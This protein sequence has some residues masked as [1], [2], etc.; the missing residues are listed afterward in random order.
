MI[1]LALIAFLVLISPGSA[2]AQCAWVLWLGTHAARFLGSPPGTP[3]GMEAL[4]REPAQWEVRGAHSTRALCEEQAERLR[5]AVRLHPPRVENGFAVS[6]P[7]CLP[8]TIDPRGPKGKSQA[9]GNWVMWLSYNRNPTPVERFATREACD[10][11]RY[12]LVGS[13]AKERDELTEEQRWFRDLWW[14]V[15][16][17]PDETP[18]KGAR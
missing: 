17:L 6:D 2:V 16:C 13:W 4:L 1:R 9:E 5:A 3:E 18:P 11:R 8:D 14:P 12:T 10:Y 7:V 15:V